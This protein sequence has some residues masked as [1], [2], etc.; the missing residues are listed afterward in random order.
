M[1]WQSVHTARSSCSP[2]GICCSIGPPHEGQK[3]IF[4]PKNCKIIE[5]NF[6][7]LSDKRVLLKG[8]SSE[9]V[10]SCRYSSKKILS[11]KCQECIRLPNAKQ[12][13]WTSKLQQIPFPT[14]D[15][16]VKGEEKCDDDDDDDEHH[17]P[18]T[19]IFAADCTVGVKGSD[20]ALESEQTTRRPLALPIRPRLKNPSAPTTTLE[21]VT[22]S[23]ER[24][25]LL[26]SACDELLVAII[27]TEQRERH[28]KEHP[29]AKPPPISNYQYS[30][31]FQDL[32][33]QQKQTHD[34]HS[35]LLL[36]RSCS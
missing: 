4:G 27:S 1:R 33:L 6:L 31:H 32:Q 34:E 35:V 17:R 18:L 15:I 28:N 14:S 10:S 12:H 24:K 29:L 3:L 30:C 23:K 8:L 25:G 20:P 9:N 21:C 22:G 19:L 16:E 26:T 2:S 11:C 13:R 7:L 36:L 5:P